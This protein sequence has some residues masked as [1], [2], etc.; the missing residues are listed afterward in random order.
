MKKWLDRQRDAVHI[1]KQ[2]IEDEI[3]RMTELRE[4]IA[5]RNVILSGKGRLRRSEKEETDFLI[6]DMEYRKI[7][8]V[9]EKLNRLRCWADH[10]TKFYDRL[11]RILGDAQ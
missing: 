10:K 11:I 7:P 2:D 9:L 1:Q 5:K 4:L 3:A 8:F 6:L